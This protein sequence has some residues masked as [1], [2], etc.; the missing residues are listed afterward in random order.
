MGS[1]DPPAF[2]VVVRPCSWAPFF[3]HLL[4]RFSRPCCPFLL[5][6]TWVFSPLHSPSLF[7]ACGVLGRVLLFGP[8]FGACPPRPVDH[9]LGVHVTGWGDLHPAPVQKVPPSVPLRTLLGVRP[10]G[11][12]FSLE[13]ENRQG[14]VLAGIPSQTCP[15]PSPSSPFVSISLTK[16]RS[17]LRSTRP[18]FLPFPGDPHRLRRRKWEAQTGGGLHEAKPTFHRGSRGWIEPHVAPQR[19]N[20]RGSGPRGRGPGARAV[21]DAPGWCLPG[22]SEAEET[23][24][25]PCPSSAEEGTTRN[26][27]REDR[28]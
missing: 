10:W 3:F 24:K 19:C 17:F 13:W 15:S 28:E 1:F 18:V 25:G 4:F 2:P 14:T 16:S 26:C 7:E 6:P 22:G 21:C 20:A 11:V 23:G 8:C 27:S 9:K 5:P 12:L